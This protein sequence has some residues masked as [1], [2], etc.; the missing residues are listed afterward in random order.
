MT[1]VIAREG[2][3]S[4]PDWVPVSRVCCVPRHLDPPR[5]AR[6]SGGRGRPIWAASS[7]IV[8]EGYAHVMV[9]TS[10][11]ALVTSLFTRATVLLT[12]PSATSSVTS[13]ATSSPGPDGSDVEA[14][15]ARSDD[16]TETAATWPAIRTGASPTRPGPAGGSSAADRGPDSLGRRD[17]AAVRR[18]RRTRGRCA[19]RDTLGA[20]RR[21]TGSTANRDL[22][23]P[24][25][26]HQR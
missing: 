9:R 22:D 3:T 24:D 16:G 23:K 10:H 1:R 11:S 13:S 19:P 4:P 2:Y 15:P 20:R 12:L 7:R 25:N 18:D 26:T 6:R 8:V 17:G 5:S 14:I 21:V